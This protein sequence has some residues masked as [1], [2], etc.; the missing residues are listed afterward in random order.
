MP[1]PEAGVRRVTVSVQHPGPGNSMEAVAAQ[2]QQALA[3]AARAGPRE[4]RRAR[5]RSARGRRRAGGP[6]DRSASSTACCTTRA[7][8][9]K[10]SARSAAR[11][12]S[13]ATRARTRTQRRSHPPRAQPGRRFEQRIGEIEDRRQALLDGDRAAAGH[14]RG[15]LED[16]LFEA[17]EE[18]E[19]RKQEW[20]IEREISD[21]PPHALVMPWARG[22]EDDRRFR[23]S[24]GVVASVC[25]LFALILP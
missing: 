12:C 9:W 22:G 4:A 23:K 6:R 11:N 17:Q 8:H 19:R 24:L 1:Q 20:I 5:A 16:D 2:D 13:G 7:A 10:R 15:L 25:L 18:E 3:C 21:L 14:A